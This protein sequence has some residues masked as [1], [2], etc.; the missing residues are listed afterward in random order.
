MK[1]CILRGQNQKMC[2]VCV[3]LWKDIVNDSNYDSKI[4]QVMQ[5]GQP[6]PLPLPLVEV[7]RAWAEAKL[8]QVMESKVSNRA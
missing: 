7:M 6:P 5:Q 4:L 2:I 1:I 3:E 8:E